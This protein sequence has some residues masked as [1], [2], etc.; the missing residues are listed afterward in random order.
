M[1]PY[2][3]LARQALSSAEALLALGDYNGAVNRAYYACHDA[4]RGTLHL[5][6]NINTD[7]IK[8]H[9]GLMRYFAQFVVRT[10]L[11]SEEIGPFMRREMELRHIADYGAGITD[12]SEAQRAVDDARLFVAAC[13]EAILRKSNIS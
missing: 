8:T 10:G 13:A 9:T 12:P 2:I 5:L 6:A 11:I 3:E 1:R 7:Q 4:A